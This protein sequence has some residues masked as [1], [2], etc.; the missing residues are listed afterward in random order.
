MKI[1]IADNRRIDTAK[2]KGADKS[3]IGIKITRIACSSFT[4][5]SKIS[6]YRLS[7]T[8]LSAMVII[9]MIG[10]ID[11]S[12]TMIDAL[13]GRSGGGCQFMI[14]W[15]AGLV[16]MTS[17]SNMLVIFQG[18][19]RSLKGWQMHGFPMNLYFAEMLTLVGWNQGKFTI[20]QHGE[21]SFPMVPARVNKDAEKEDAARPSGRVE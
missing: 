14:G 6:S 18:T 2:K 16:C 13:M 17:L 4:I 3:E 1:D 12:K 19:K 8:A 7:E 15:G 11:D 5:G 20:N 21:Q 9:S 10:Q